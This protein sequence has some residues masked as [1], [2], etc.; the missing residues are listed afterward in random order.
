MQLSADVTRELLNRAAQLPA[1]LEKADTLHL[2]DAEVALFIARA[3]K[4]ICLLARNSSLENEV[5]LAEALFYA[6][7]ERANGPLEDGHVTALSF[8]DGDLKLMTH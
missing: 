6:A 3:A 1:L 2:D 7:Y 8:N 5:K 4:T